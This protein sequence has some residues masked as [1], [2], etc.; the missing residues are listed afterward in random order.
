MCVIKKQQEAR[1]IRCENAYPQYSLMTVAEIR[2]DQ[3]ADLE[4]LGIK[5]FVDFAE[6]FRFRVTMIVW[7]KVLFKFQTSI[8]DV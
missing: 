3:F 7:S 4:T 1:I 6:P 8:F 2:D 5:N